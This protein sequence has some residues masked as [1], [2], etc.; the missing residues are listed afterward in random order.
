VGDQMKLFHMHILLMF[1]IALFFCNTGNAQR[2]NAKVTV[3]IPRLREQP[4]IREA[5][6]ELNQKLEDYINGTVW[7][8]E[9]QDININCTIQLIVETYTDRGSDRVFRTQFLIS[10]PSGEN[11][12]DRAAEFTYY[13]RGQSFDKYRTTYDPLLNLVEYYIYMV[14]AGELD[15]YELFAGNP[16]YDRAQDLANQGQLSNYSTGWSGRLDE[17]IQASD[18]D[19]VP[20]REAKFYYY[21][22]LYFVEKE[23]NPQYAEQLTKAVVDRLA[24]LYSKRPNSP[25]LK[26]FLDSHYQEFCKLFQFDKDRSNID[27]MIDIDARHRDTYSDCETRLSQ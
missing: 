21:E 11:F 22:G 24:V 18:G 26:R 12:Y 19:H 4:E 3:D 10:T 27:R 17:A 25:A 2:L 23:P 6:S 7:N 16:F 5:L 1:M 13:A 15:T 9:Y 14:I 20:L 8:E